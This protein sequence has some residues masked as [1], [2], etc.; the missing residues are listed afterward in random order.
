MGGGSCRTSGFSELLLFI[1]RASQDIKI[2]VQSA[3]KSYKKGLLQNG[4]E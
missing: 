4:T 1:Q 3:Q 2:G